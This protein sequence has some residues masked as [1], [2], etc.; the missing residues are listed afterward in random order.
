MTTPTRHAT[1]SATNR[2]WREY[3]ACATVEP[4]LHFPVAHT[5]RWREQTV[6]AKAICAACPVRQHCLNW[7]LETRQPAGIWGGKTEQE[8]RV[9]L[10]IP[11]TPT[12]RCMNRQAWIEEQLT[13]GASQRHLADCLGVTSATMNRCVTRWQAERAAGEVQAA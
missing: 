10:G 4:D 7:A 1:T 13:A 3:A 9:L 2:N 6:Q 8:R 5:P 11:E 12:E